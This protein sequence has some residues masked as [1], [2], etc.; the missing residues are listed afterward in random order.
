MGSL[1]L[2]AL[3]GVKLQMDAFY[4]C[5]YGAIVTFCIVKAIIEVVTEDG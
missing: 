2:F 4:W 1:I 3:I 5:I